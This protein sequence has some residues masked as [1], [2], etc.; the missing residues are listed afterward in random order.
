M[1]A[2]SNFTPSG[3]NIAQTHPDDNFNNM[4]PY[5]R[6]FGN[7]C[8]RR[9]SLADWMEMSFCWGTLSPKGIFVPAAQEKI[10]PYPQNDH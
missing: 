5:N 3:V 4:I 1:F 9:A 8:R 7:A 6:P 2:F 10:T